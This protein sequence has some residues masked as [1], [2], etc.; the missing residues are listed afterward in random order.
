MDTGA[1]GT[2]IRERIGAAA[3][4]WGRSVEL[5]RA[6]R[7][8]FAL[9]GCF[10]RYD[11]ESILLKVVALHSLDS[12]RTLPTTRWAAHAHDVLRSIDPRKVGPELVDSLA[13]LPGT[14]LAEN[15]RAITLASRFAHYFVD[16]D[17]FPVLDSWSESA[18]DRLVAAHDE[19][20]T[21]YVDFARRHAALASALGVSRPRRLWCFLWLSGQYRAWARNP[22]TPI[23][24]AAR[25][26]FESGAPELEALLFGETAAP[27]TE[28]QEPAAALPS[29]PGQPTLA[30]A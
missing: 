30:A 28:T 8:L 16:V 24:R 15:K 12:S 7:G 29:T 25:A 9:Q 6:E 11:P 3:T 19:T 20:A 14:R 2:T 27:R 1:V 21:R 23:H 17:R 18:L 26:L 4:L 22:R 13:A 10:P 5:V